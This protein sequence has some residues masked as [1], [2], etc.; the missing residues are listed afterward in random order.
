MSRPKKQ[1]LKPRKDGRYCCKYHG[2]Q[3][4]G[5]SSDEALA[6]RDA[7]KRQ[8][9]EGERITQHVTLG[10]YAAGWLPVHK[11]GVKQ[12]TYNGYASILEAVI[13]PA[14]GIQLDQLSTDDIARLYS[15]LN[16]KSASYIHKAK[17]LLT[18]ILDS[19]TDAGYMRKNPCRAQSIKPPKGTRG[20]HRAIT[21]E[22]KRLI[23]STPHRM[24]LA[25][26][27]MLFCGLR[28]GEALALDASDISGDML[29]VSRAVSFVGNRPVVSTPKTEA[30]I[31]S[32]PVPPI[33]RPFLGDLRGLAA[34]GSNGAYMT[35]QAWKRGWES[36]LRALSTSAGHP[37]SIRAHDLRHTYCTML[38]DAGV[39]IHQA[40]IWMGHADEKMILRIYD[41]PGRTRE[42]EAKNRL[43]FA[44][45]MQ[46]GMQNQLDP[47]K[48]L[49][50]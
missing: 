2:I 41:H 18:A 13:T 47:A 22:E 10:E 25:A 32:I 7:Y 28:R 30:G 37:V 39:D 14:A 5:N 40:I 6:L 31:R 29:T 21:D 49:Y 43:N 16:G 46:S 42:E 24:Q 33:L 8:E 11:A 1:V 27:L 9:A 48:T 50:S 45:G 36:F 12:S 38:R 20:T 3:F 35:E 15:R 4:M 44:F 26:L 34:K 23:L 19:A 17:I